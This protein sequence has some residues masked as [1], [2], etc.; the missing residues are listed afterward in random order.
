MNE[1]GYNIL[2][3][4]EQG[5]NGNGSENIEV[6]IFKTYFDF[7]CSPNLLLWHFGNPVIKTL[8]F[9]AAL[10][11]PRIIFKPI[12]LVVPLTDFIVLLG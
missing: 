11:K 12:D 5:G 6:Y 3:E 2:G 9:P 10:S 4:E 1:V 7:V 8:V